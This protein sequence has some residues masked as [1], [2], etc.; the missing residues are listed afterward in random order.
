MF[1]NI[2]L[3]FALFSIFSRMDFILPSGAI[4]WAFPSIILGASYFIKNIQ[5]IKNKMVFKKVIYLILSYILLITYH[6]AFNGQKVPIFNIFHIVTFI[7]VG[8]ILMVEVSRLDRIK[9]AKFLKT[10]IPLLLLFSVLEITTP[11]L[12]LLVLIK[13]LFLSY[14][15]YSSQL[16]DMQLHGGA[17]RPMFL[18]QEPSHF[19]LFYSFL[20]GTFF[21]LSENKHAF[22]HS[23]LFGFL[24]LLVIRSPISILGIVQIVILLNVKVD[25]IVKRG[26]VVTILFISLILGFLY[27]V[28]KA[29]I[30]ARLEEIISFSGH[31]NLA[32]IFIPLFTLFE[33]LRI[34]PIMGLGLDFQSLDIALM[35][36]QIGINFGLE[37]S[38]WKTA[39]EFLK[40]S[41]LQHWINFGL[42][43]GAIILFWM[44]EILISLGL[45]K[46][47]IVI[48]LIQAIMMLGISAYADPRVWAIFFL[49]LGVLLIY[50]NRD[51]ENIKNVN[52]SMISIS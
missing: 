5:I 36:R 40:N 17:I 33:T 28:S 1:K 52:K 22:R 3:I 34:K 29:V 31:S 13:G 39:P 27:L 14:S 20:L 35:L 38:S 37:L 24:G 18:F 32:R 49:N 45:K 11:F 25:R 48:F 4:I 8:F 2:L 46:D 10:I 42:F 12:N 26:K 44:K 6:V 50:Y 7:L 23:L 15:D 21:M 30:G 19:A 41:F 51:Q 47:M 9:T 43:G 16:R